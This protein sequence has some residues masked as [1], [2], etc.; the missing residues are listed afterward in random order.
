MS[1]DGLE[2]V[3]RRRARGKGAIVCQIRGGSD[4]A[5]CVSA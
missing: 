3:R 5:I 4:T 1:Y 2:E